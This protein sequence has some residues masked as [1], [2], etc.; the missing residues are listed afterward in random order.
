MAL[1][2]PS[3]TMTNEIQN[4]LNMHKTRCMKSSIFLKNT[5]NF[6][7]LSDIELGVSVQEL[8]E[9]SLFEYWERL[10]PEERTKEKI[11][12]ITIEILLSILELHQ[13]MHDY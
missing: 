7:S 11:V 12:E 6:V 10:E 9:E 5:W 4:N 1:I 3:V 8:P 13:S 2:K